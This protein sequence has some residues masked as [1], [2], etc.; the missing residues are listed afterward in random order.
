TRFSRDWSSDVCSSDLNNVLIDQVAPVMYKD[1]ASGVGLN[2]K[3]IDEGRDDGIDNDGD[4]N[5]EFDDVGA[6][7]KAGTGDFGEN[8]GMPTLGEPNF[9]RTDIDE[10]DQLGFTSFLT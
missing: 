4:W 2:D 9:E 8:D 6:D 10:S 3:M 7:G 5:P 1:Y